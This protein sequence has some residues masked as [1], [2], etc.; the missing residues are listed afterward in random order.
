MNRAA[1]VA[2]LIELGLPGSR[3]SPVNRAILL[4]LLKTLAN[5]WPTAT[6]FRSIF[7]NKRCNPADDTFVGTDAGTFRARGI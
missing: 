6:N 5:W 1:L 7:Q 4:Y 3:L 2:Q